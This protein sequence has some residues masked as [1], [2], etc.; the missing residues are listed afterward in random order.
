MNNRIRKKYE[1]LFKKDEQMKLIKSQIE[2]IK[3]LARGY[4]LQETADKMNLKYCN[5]QK[6]TQLLYKKFGVNSRKELIE[7][8]LEQKIIKTS[9]ISNKYR[10]RF[11]KYQ[12]ADAQ[13]QLIEP[14]TDLEKQYIRLIIAGESKQMIVKKLHVLNIHF[15]NHIQNCICY[16]LNAK[17]IL[18]AA[19]FAYKLQLLD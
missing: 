9:D 16:K 13:P 17:N 14:L 18:Q 2:L 7:K 11:L 1:S 8:A 6:R 10:R 4:T 19:I 3:M 15:C 12:D 5:L